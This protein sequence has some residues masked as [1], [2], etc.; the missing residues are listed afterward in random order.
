MAGEGTKRDNSGLVDEGLY[1]RYAKELRL[2]GH[3]SEYSAFYFNVEGLASVSDKYG[4]Q[5]SKKVLRQY[6]GILKKFANNDEFLGYLGGDNFA[7]LIKLARTDTFRRFISDIKVET[8]YRGKM[9]EHHLRATAGIWEIGGEVQ[10][11]AQ[12]IRNPSLAFIEAKY[13]L[14][15]PYVTIAPGQVS[16]ANQQKEVT[17]AFAEAIAK[18]EFVVYYQPKIDIARNTLV[19]AEGLVRWKRGGKL[20]SPGVFIRPLEQTGDILQLDY[21]V[22]QTICRDIREWQKKGIAPVPIS[23]NFSRRN[24]LDEDL[25]ENIEYIISHSGIE[26]NMI[27]VEIQESSDPEEYA[28]MTDFIQGLHD[29]GIR[30]AMDN[31]GSGFASIS[32]LRELPVDTIKI[33]RSFI[34]TDDFSQ[35]DEI[36]LTHIIRMARELGIGVITQGVEREDQLNFVR[37]AG[38]DQIQGFF[39][40]RPLPKEEFESRLVELGKG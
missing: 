31:F 24:L 37:S 5:E 9:M 4:Y 8:V 18:R 12:V 6:M 35:K 25:A 10:E 26:K 14:Y 34:N 38:C 11:I 2:R 1:L 3:L 27:E 7:A 15:Q 21:Y 32:E 39:F 28:V 23:S 29:R 17:D 40:D 33:D 22:L 20:V 16:R 36:I 13:V 30:T 19:G